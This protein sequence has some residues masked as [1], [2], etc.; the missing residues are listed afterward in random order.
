M[1]HCK[2]VKLF[3]N[4]FR[5]PYSESKLPGPLKT[6]QHFC[7]ITLMLFSWSASS[8]ASL[9]F[10]ELEKEYSGYFDLNREIV[11]LHL[12]K[13]TVVPKENLWLSAYVY[14]PRMEIPN[15]ET[16]NLNVNIYDEKGT[17]IDSKTLLI[18]DGKGSAYLPLDPEKFPPGNYALKASTKYMGNFR[19]EDLSYLQPFT[20]L[21]AEVKKDMEEGTETIYDLQLLPEGG[22]L[23][24]GAMNSV[25]V[26]LI[27]NRGHGVAFTDGLVLDGDNNEITRF[28]SNK[29][30]MSRFSFNPDLHEDYKIVVRIYNGQ[31]ISQ[32]LEK[33]EPVG[34]S[35]IT[36]ERNNEYVFSIKT[37]ETGM[38][39]VRDGTFI[40]A[41]HKDGI[42][43][44]FEFRFPE[45][46]LEVNLLVSKDSLFAGVNTI[47][48]FDQELK[49][50]L[51]RMFF[52][53]NR[54]K[55]SEVSAKLE[56]K[57]TDSLS[58]QIISNP[59]VERASLSV[60][61]LPSETMA[62][63]PEH[64]I[65]SAFL[66]KP[67]VKG[68]IEEATYYFSPDNERRKLYDLDLLL[69]TQGWSKYNWENTFKKAPRQEI[70]PELGFRLEGSVQGRN[71]KKENRLFIRSEE[72]GLFKI[73]ELEEDNTFKVENIFVADSTSLSFG[74]L[75]DRNDKVSK[76]AINAKILPLKKQQ[77]LDTTFTFFPRNY[78][79]QSEVIIPEGFTAD[80]V[81]L[82]TVE[83]IGTIKD[84]DKFSNELRVFG[85]AVEI[86]DTLAD[87]FFY[88]TD[89]IATKGFRVQQEIGG[90]KI[91]SMKLSTLKGPSNSGRD[92]APS[93]DVLLYFNG[94][95][96]GTDTSFLH[97][98]QSREV[99]S[100]VIN[101]MG[102]GEG[103]NG[104]NGVIKINMKK[105]GV[106]HNRTE[107]IQDI[108][109]NNGFTENK[110]F[111]APRYSSYEN[112][113]YR[114]YGA[115]DWQSNLILGPEGTVE[116]SIPNTRQSEI[117]IFVEGMNAEGVLISE[118][119]TVKT[120]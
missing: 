115:I 99:E 9:D 21:G 14:N 39:Q 83:L 110:E 8:Q 38:E 69:L 98:L 41:I 47:T 119:L 93:A 23:L 25:G 62:Y 72:T 112:S 55:T 81:A 114:K 88:I 85:E 11:F 13:T 43:E 66:L 89:Y 36:T 53:E 40:A 3:I 32:K 75:N 2:K 90:V 79:A 64:N 52:N 61:V 42:V 103:M 31:E 116:F 76:P 29:F 102:Y 78:I 70:E 87:R 59:A 84:R 120:E 5:Q 101:K 28:R 68:S 27:N 46:K 73:V 48:I 20:V 65:L 111:Y 37:N 18:S 109:A 26:K 7:L 104:V 106:D 22:H 91:T 54:L 60:S 44:D 118:T 67:Y 35:L 56:G 24:S 57:R 77:D 82:E 95:P 63:N 30:G 51:E 71:K 49:P 80:A 6:L 17:Y 105:G 1:Y 113:S 10:T 19:E 100:I 94:V 86:T 96:V 15:R 92:G 45:D 4:P 97:R 34:I 12:N 33:P 74:L 107:T 50:V 117:K 108:I 58:L 16:V